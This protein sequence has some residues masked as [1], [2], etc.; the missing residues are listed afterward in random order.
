[1]PI[2]QQQWKFK[3]SGE[4]SYG[5]K[6]FH[7]N[8]ENFINLI[9]ISN[10]ENRI[11]PTLLARMNIDKNLMDYII[12]NAEDIEIQLL[13]QKFTVSI[14]DPLQT[15]PAV[16]Y[17]NDT[18]LVSVGSDINYNKELDYA[19][20]AESELPIEDRFRQTYIGLISKSCI[21][22]NK[23]VAN[24]VSHQTLMQDLVLSYLLQ[25]CHL[26]V[27]PFTYNLMNNNLIIPP[28]DTMSSIIEY[29]NSI[30]VFYDTKY[31]LFFDE[32]TVTYLL[33]RTGKG[34]K[35]KG[36]KY[37]VVNLQMRNSTES[38]NLVI[39]MNDNPDTNSFDVDV[40]ILDSNYN[41]DQDTTKIIDSIDT[42][43][44]PSLERSKISND[45]ITTLKTQIQQMLT[46]FLQ[47][48][49]R[50]A[51]ASLNIGSIISDA[52]PKVRFSI[53]SIQNV[54]KNM[55]N[56]SFLSN[57]TF[58]TSAKA[59]ASVSQTVQTKFQELLKK[60]PTSITTTNSNG[61]TMST[62]IMTAT[63]KSIQKSLSD[64]RFMAAEISLAT[65]ESVRTN[66]K[67][68]MKNTGNAYY[69]QDFMDNAMMSVCYPNVQDVTN[70]TSQGIKAMG[71]D[72][73]KAIDIMRDVTGDIGCFPNFSNTTSQL[74]DQV[75][76]IINKL[77]KGLTSK[78]NDEVSGANSP[79]GGCLKSAV[80]LLDDLTII[81]DTSDKYGTIVEQQH[82]K[83]QDI[84][85][86][87]QKGL[88]SFESY[89]GSLA[90]AAANDI[91]SKI[92]SK[93]PTRIFGNTSLSIDQLISAQMNGGGCFG[94]ANTWPAIA[95]S[96][97]GT[98]NFSDLSKLATSVMN[99]DLSNVGS[100]LNHFNFD[101][102][103]GRKVPPIVGDI[104][105]TLIIK[106]KNDNV[107]QAKTIKSEI[108]LAKNK[109]SINKYGIDPSVFTPNKQYVIKN[110]SGHSK[111]DGKFILNQ[112][113]EVYTRE[114]DNFIC[115]TQL[116]FSKTMENVST[117]D[118][119]DVSTANSNN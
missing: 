61:T 100:M 71:L 84:Q 65:T 117:N 19:E 21:N 86:R 104:V 53:E 12:K 82:K 57:K 88:K 14:D 77:M 113:I 32:P 34:V 22:A 89:L 8:P 92:I 38:N 72:V 11:M 112:K 79:L 67:N 83:G 3:I 20:N 7:L 109:L 31:I 6:T 106:A 1:M 110:Y 40:S 17:I 102:N 91:K 76:S 29:L 96:V 99:F 93:I 10:Y 30:Q 39:G 36:E 9:R 13:V 44:N 2:Q 47:N 98:L 81:K 63:E 54:A 73:N 25:N 58:N 87:L 85:D 15:G 78:I 33:S 80:E 115:N 69:Q 119:A 49:I 114:D 37:N 94:M 68:S 66:F 43:T 35:M 4:I 103:I 62:T 56:N 28:L 52:V 97:G 105:G 108:E 60:I 101:L 48:T 95:S 55:I 18:F 74:Q 51:M 23:S 42:V 75:Q 70:P 16:D 90:N 24:E 46:N 27:E 50:N 118:A 116:Y 59:P 26:L 45:I 107:N 111:R 5:D 41:I 64:S